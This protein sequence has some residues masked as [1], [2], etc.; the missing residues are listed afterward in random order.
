MFHSTYTYY[1]RWCLKAFQADKP[2]QKGGFC[3][4]AHKQAH[5]RAYS[6]WVTN[7]PHYAR[8]V[9]KVIRRQRNARK[10]RK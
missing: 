3:C 4:D 7:Q 9:N 10:L 6:R 8:S 5:W 2:L 1:C